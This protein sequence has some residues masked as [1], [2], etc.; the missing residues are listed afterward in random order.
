[1][2]NINRQT[3]KHHDCHIIL[4]KCRQEQVPTQSLTS[5][6]AHISAALSEHLTQMKMKLLTSLKTEAYPGCQTKSGL[7]S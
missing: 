6:H 1:M 3:T 5:C 2:E 4:L 7:P